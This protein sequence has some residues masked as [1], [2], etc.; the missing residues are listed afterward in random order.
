MSFQEN[1][2][3]TKYGLNWTITDDMLKMPEN[4]KDNVS[5]V[6]REGNK[7][8]FTKPNGDLIDIVLNQFKGAGTYGK[9]YSSL[10]QID[11]GVDLVVKI[12][13][14][15]GSTNSTKLE[16]DTI[17]EA[18][19]QILIYEASK[20]FK[21]T[22]INLIGPFCPKFYL[23][24]RENQTMFIVME[25]I[26]INLDN[27]LRNKFDQ[28]IPAQ[29]AAYDAWRPPASKFVKQTIL[30]ITTILKELYKR[31]AYNHRDFKP[32]NIMFNMVNEK[33]NIKL[34]DFGFSCLKYKNLGLAAISTS[35]WAS[36]LTSCD[37]ETRDLHAFFYFFCNNTYYKDIECPLKRVI[38][39]L[40]SSDEI[41]PVKWAGT[42]SKYDSTN[43]N[44]SPIRPQNLSLDIVHNV[45]KDI[46]FSKANNSCSPINYI[47]VKHL[48]KLYKNTT[49]FLTIEE[50]SKSISD[51]VKEEY[52][53]YIID[54]LKE[55]FNKRP[56]YDSF[57]FWS[58]SGSERQLIDEFT[59]TVYLSE[60]TYEE[61]TKSDFEP[62]QDFLIANSEYAPVDRL[63]EN[64]L[65][66]AVRAGYEPLV[67]KILD[68][69][70][71]NWVNKLNRVNLS[72]LD[73][74]ININNVSIQNKLIEKG[75][76]TKYYSC[77]L[78][79]SLPETFNSIANT[80][81]QIFTRITF[82]NIV[83]YAIRVNDTAK[84]LKLVEL[85]IPVNSYHFYHDLSAITD[86]SLLKILWDKY[87]NDT[88]IN[89]K[90]YGVS[91]L[92]N[93][94]NSANLEL[95]KLF[96]SHPKILTTAIDNEGKTCLHYAVMA[97]VKSTGKKKED[98]LEIIKLLIE[99][100]PALPDIRDKNKK[101]PANPYYA[102][103]S[104]ARTYI[105]ERKSTLFTKRKNTNL[106]KSGGL[107]KTR[108]KTRRNKKRT[109]FK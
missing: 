63:G 32:D 9:T 77:Q 11:K 37:S 20:D 1:I 97:Y 58:Q 19:I 44:S 42:Y 68:K 104:E 70:G 82:D 28:E 18:L 25:E 2:D 24:G 48:V 55:E 60:K 84:C 27:V 21:D 10:T 49:Y 109:A 101:G 107:R 79:M 103:D 50:Y 51:K 99:A 67:D 93:A 17:Q 16:Y 72:P 3:F 13:D 91:S 74:A 73:I 31:I 92:S 59:Y 43:R 94:A 52:M 40:M 6:N 78:I 7:L 87:K 86:T 30:Q 90:Y 39:A 26:S 56:I 23:L 33:P 71:Y 62:L 41:E 85:N 38:K 108:Q 36:R 29:K 45:F 69:T 95:V 46:E 54:K 76:N 61:K 83:N 100:N 106:G 81:P 53:R 89:S 57:G 8:A 96:L 88:E 34:I 22:S 47:W 80:N 66:K 64:L 65:H 15:T 35:V 102:K 5:S 98:A 75:A 105:K 14:F 12:I 4:Y